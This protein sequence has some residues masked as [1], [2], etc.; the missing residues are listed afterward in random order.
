MGGGDLK[1]PERISPACF[2]PSTPAIGAETRCIQVRVAMDCMA[3]GNKVLPGHYSWTKRRIH[4]S[5]RPVGVD[6]R[7]SPSVTHG[8]VS[9]IILSVSYRRA[10][11]GCRQVASTAAA[12]WNYTKTPSRHLASHAVIRLHLLETASYCEMISLVLSTLDGVQ[13]LQS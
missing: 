10:W 1:A 6:G 11:F 13:R 3:R 4:G 5:S 7:I 12:F 9:G 2:V 8:S